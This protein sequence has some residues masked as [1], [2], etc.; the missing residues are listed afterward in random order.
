MSDGIILLSCVAS[1]CFIARLWLSVH[2]KCLNHSGAFLR[3]TGQ[4]ATQLEE[5]IGWGFLRSPRRIALSDGINQCGLTQRSSSSS[6][7]S[8]VRGFVH[9]VGAGFFFLTWNIWPF[10]VNIKRFSLCLSA[11][12]FLKWTKTE[13]TTGTLMNKYCTVLVCVVL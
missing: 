3:D 8:D 10:S 4:E 1:G 13:R 12:I 9:L 7:Y 6:S 5:L 11:A 2:N